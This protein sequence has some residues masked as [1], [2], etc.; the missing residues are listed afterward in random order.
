MFVNLSLI[1]GRFYTEKL[2]LPPYR[3]VKRRESLYAW[4]CFISSRPS[5]AFVPWLLCLPIN[6]WRDNLAH[7]Q[8]HQC[9]HKWTV[10]HW[11]ISHTDSL[12]K[13]GDAIMEEYQ[14]LRNILWHGNPCHV[15]IYTEMWRYELALFSSLMPERER[16]REREREKERK[17]EWEGRS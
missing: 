3:C 15:R 16:K 7:K 13:S 11:P 5:G 1:N 8:S 9:S 10:G 12:S 4:V 14:S 2:W 6:G 17:R